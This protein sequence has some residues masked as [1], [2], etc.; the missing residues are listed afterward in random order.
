METRSVTFSFEATIPYSNILF[1]G[2]TPGWPASM[3]QT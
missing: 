2:T 1:W 3:S